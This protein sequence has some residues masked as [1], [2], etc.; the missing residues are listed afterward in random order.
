LSKAAAAGERV[1]DIL[2]QEPEVQDLPGAIPAPAFR[3]A[4]RFCG[5]GFD[6]ES[7]QT[8]LEDIDLDVLPGQHVALIG[9]SGIGKS[10]LVSL[11]LRLYDPLRGRVM[12]DL[13]DIREY[14]LKSLRAQISVVLQDS[15]LFA[16]SVRDNIAYGT[17]AAAQDEIE[18]AARL[19]NAHEFIGALPQGYDTIVGERGVTLSSGQRQRIAIARAAIREAPI[20]VLDEPT[21]GL[22]EEN[23]RTVIEALERLARGRTTFLITHNL[24]LATRCDL[25]IYLEGGRILERGTHQSLYDQHGRYYDLY[26]RQHGID[27]NLF[28]APGEGDQIPEGPEKPRVPGAVLPT[29]ASILRGGTA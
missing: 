15:I 29:A 2:E 21:T 28:L 7:G 14:T 18:R 27:A 26:T 25:I 11:L 23:E 13:R 16:G 12:I 17:A 8:V 4:V 3:G 9:P 24:Q 19:A 5:L 6:Y 1:L 10:T 22:D 20:L